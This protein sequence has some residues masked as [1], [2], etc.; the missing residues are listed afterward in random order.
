MTESDRDAQ[1]MRQI[2]DGLALVV[3]AIRARYP[4]GCS[5]SSTTNE[6]EKEE[7]PE[8]VEPEQRFLRRVSNG[9]GVPITNV[10]PLGSHRGESTCP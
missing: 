9:F 10:Q 6:D 3:G 1:M 4:V 8:A 7:H 5:D 2:A